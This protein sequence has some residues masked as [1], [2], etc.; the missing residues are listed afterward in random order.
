MPPGSTR[1]ASFD[2]LVSNG[3]ALLLA[4]ARPRA[5]D[6]TRATIWRSRDGLQWTETAHP[7]T[8]GSVTAVAVDGDT[9]LATGNT[10]GSGESDFVWRSDDGG[11][12]W[13]EVAKGKGVF[14]APAPEMGRPNVSGLLRHDG[15]W[16]ASG[17]RSDGYAAIWISRDGARWRQVLGP[18]V[19]GAAS[20]VQG[21]AGSLLASWVT[22]AWFTRD[23][24]RWGAPQAVTVP[25]RSYLS[26]V[27]RGATTAVAEDLDRHGQPTPLLRSTDGGRTWVEDAHFLAMFADARVA[28]INRAG[29]LW[30]G[31]GASG[32]TDASGA[33]SHVDAWISSDRET[34]TPLPAELYGGRGRHR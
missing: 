5:D 34:W 4:G 17:G 8:T 33:P 12:S 10:S 14:G 16:V 1:G 18:N 31:A 6:S 28:S 3:D 32:T 25:A 21:R 26:S 20:I 13:T 27:A 11:M 29:G 23:V 24:T 9:A 15:W 22:T 30:V 19:A 7:S 2:A